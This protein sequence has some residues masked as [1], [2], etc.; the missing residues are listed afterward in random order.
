MSLFAGMRSLPLG[1]L[2]VV[3]W[4]V[5]CVVLAIGILIVVLA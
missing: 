2:F 5:V 1:W 4:G 3:V